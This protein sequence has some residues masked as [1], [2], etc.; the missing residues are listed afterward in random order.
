MAPVTIGKLGVGKTTGMAEE[1]GGE[2]KKKT[3]GKKL[4]LLIV[5]PILLLAGAGAGV[6]FSGILDSKEEAAVEGAAEG[7]HGEAADGH[8]TPGVGHYLAL[9]PMNVSLN[10]GGRRQQYLKMQLTLELAKVEDQ[11]A[12]EAVMPRI[13]DNFQVFLRELRVEELQGSEGVYRIREELLARVNKATA[14]VQ[15]RDV[16][17][18]EIVIQ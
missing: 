12:V 7:E 6:F 16:L 2:G 3:S 15:V 17:F 1:D 9:A 11:P 14:P 5:L 13:V 4:I 18:Q 10:P 8:G